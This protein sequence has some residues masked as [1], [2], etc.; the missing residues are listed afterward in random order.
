MVWLYSH[1]MSGRVLLGS[2]AYASQASTGKYMGQ[3]ISV[4]SPL[5]PAG[6]YCTGR[7]VS[8]DFIHL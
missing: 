1:W 8:W 5:A 3:K 4:F 2:L 7:L 6:S